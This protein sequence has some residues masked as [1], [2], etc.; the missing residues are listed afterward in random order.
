MLASAHTFSSM[1]GMMR[2]VD[3][4]ESFEETNIATTLCYTMQE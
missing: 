1:I 3:Y 4:V 2:F